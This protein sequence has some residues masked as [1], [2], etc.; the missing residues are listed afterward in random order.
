MV[1]TYFYFFPNA[2]T[3]R[4][5]AYC[6]KNGGITCCD[7][8]AEFENYAEPLFHFF[9]YLLFAGAHCKNGLFK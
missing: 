3:F 1:N 5:P 8:P 4:E 7:T 9:L 2:A 6:M